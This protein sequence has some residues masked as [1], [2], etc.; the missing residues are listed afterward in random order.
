MLLFYNIKP[1][2]KDLLTFFEYAWDEVY[3]DEHSIRPPDLGFTV[4]LTYVKLTSSLSH[5]KPPSQSKLLY[6][7]DHI[8][9]RYQNKQ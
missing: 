4:K 6:L 8:K 2:S 5:K 7:Q 3:N 1:N 9:K